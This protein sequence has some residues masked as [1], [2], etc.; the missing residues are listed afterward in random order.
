[1]NSLYITGVLPGREKFSLFIGLHG[2]FSV[3]AQGFDTY[4][5]KRAKKRSDM[6]S[7]ARALI[8]ALTPIRLQNRQGNVLV[9]AISL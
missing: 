4:G 6:A 1:M 8:A 7:A 5:H 3:A 9:P 2:F